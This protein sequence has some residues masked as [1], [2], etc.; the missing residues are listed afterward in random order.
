MTHVARR[1]VPAGLDA[2]CLLLNWLRTK[3]YA[4]P[5]LQLAS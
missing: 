1:R 2:A 5:C 4:K 3:D